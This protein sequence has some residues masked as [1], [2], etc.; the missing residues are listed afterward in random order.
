MKTKME[1]I[2]GKARRTDAMEWIVLDW[3]QNATDFTN[4]PAGKE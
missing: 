3:N 4:I 1:I 2:I